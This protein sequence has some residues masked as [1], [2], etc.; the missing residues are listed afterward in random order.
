MNLK[1]IITLLLAVS[2]L[3]VAYVVPSLAETTPYKEAMARYEKMKRDYI[4]ICIEYAG[5]YTTK[6]SRFYGREVIGVNPDGSYQLSPWRCLTEASY[7]LSGDYVYFNVPAT[8][9]TSATA[10]ISCRAQTGH[11]AASSGPVQTARSQKRS[12]SMPPDW[13]GL[14]NSSSR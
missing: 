6:A 12:I 3:C 11:T 14:W 5:M 1:K 8:T 9:C 7:V 4:N 2:M 10:L 13:S